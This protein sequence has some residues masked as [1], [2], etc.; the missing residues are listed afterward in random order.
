M[1]YYERNLPHYQP[2]KS[3]FFITFRLADS[4]PVELL[5]IL[6][7][8]FLIEKNKIIHGVLS[9]DVYRRKIYDLQKKYFGKYDELLDSLKYGPSWLANTDVARCVT[10]KL[11]EFCESK[12]ELISY[13]LLP[14]H[15]HLVFLPNEDQII[16][17]DNLK[18]KTKNYPVADTM[19][20]IKGATAR[21]ANR[22][23]GRTGRFWHHESLDHVVRNDQELDSI[24]H[25]VMYNPVK[26]GLVYNQTDWKWSYSIYEPT[27]REKLS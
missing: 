1:I 5:G 3:I 6:R 11:M 8:E 26:A 22:I 25:Y 14:N 18:G 21:E 17:S 24:I 2:E 13:S 9:L 19:R 20:L 10:N 16:S 27:A 7:K 12:Y 15:V 4:I 23:L